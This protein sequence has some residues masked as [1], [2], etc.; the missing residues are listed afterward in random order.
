M[1]T[2]HQGQSPRGNPQFPPQPPGLV[3]KILAALLSAA[4]LV[5]AFMFSLVALAIVACGGILFGGWLWWKT[6]QV[7]KIFNEQATRQAEAGGRVI[8]GEV[9]RSETATDS[10]GRHF[11]R[12]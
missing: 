9:I 5:V 2:E 1:N 4:F 7:R 11:P 6:R 8:E 10:A 3:G 12:D